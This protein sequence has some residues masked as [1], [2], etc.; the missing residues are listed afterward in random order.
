MWGTHPQKQKTWDRGEFFEA[1]SNIKIQL[2]LEMHTSICPEREVVVARSSNGKANY[3]KSLLNFGA[4]KR[5]TRKLTH[6]NIT[7]QII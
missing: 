6:T 5:G 4:N 3:N 2:H 7:M 1:I